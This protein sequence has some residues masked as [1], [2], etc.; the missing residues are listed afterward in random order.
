MFHHPR[1]EFCATVKESTPFILTGNPLLV[2]AAQNA[3]PLGKNTSTE[4]ESKHLL[5]ANQ[6]GLYVHS[7]TQG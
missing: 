4:A 2:L 6:H 5:K 1:N 7:C 3:A